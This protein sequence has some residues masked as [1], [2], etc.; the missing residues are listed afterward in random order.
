MTILNSS[1]ALV[2][3]AGF[4]LAFLGMLWRLVAAIVRHIDAT[5][6]NT[7]ALAALGTTLTTHITRSDARATAHE[8]RIR[9]LE[10]LNHVR[11]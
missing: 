4:A 9:H 6:A 7:T 2:T 8:T 5:K 1:G 3:L 10:R 11:T